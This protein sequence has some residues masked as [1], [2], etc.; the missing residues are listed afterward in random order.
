MVREALRRGERLR[1]VVGSHDNLT[2]IELA[3][4]PL[5]AGDCFD[6][7]TALFKHRQLPDGGYTTFAIEQVVECVSRH[8]AGDERTSTTHH[9]EPDAPNT[10][11]G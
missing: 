11:S 6:L 4:V 1:E 5:L 8:V 2:I 9:H 7:V 10:G 3:T